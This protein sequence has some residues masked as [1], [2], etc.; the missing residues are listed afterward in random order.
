MLETVLSIAAVLIAALALLLSAQNFRREGRHRDEDNRFVAM[1]AA[2]RLGVR[3]GALSRRNDALRA[4]QRALLAARGMSRSGAWEKVTQDRDRSEKR[5]GD[6]E[7]MR[8]GLLTKIEGLK[9]WALSQ[10]M[11][12]LG[13]LEDM[14]DEIEEGLAGEE[15]TT[16]DGQ[17]EFREQAEARR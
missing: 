2:K 17:R 15:A 6:L 5:L 16:K 11:I 14:V 3:I 1:R 9:G 7:G 8:K 12:N 13:V 4:E 10:E